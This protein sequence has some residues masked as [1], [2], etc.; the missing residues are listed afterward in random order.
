MSPYG[1]DKDLGGDSKPNDA[2][3]ERCVTRVMKSGKDKSSAIAICKSTM[4]KSKDNHSE[5]ELLLD[6]IL[7]NPNRVGLVLDTD[8]TKYPGQE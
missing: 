3:M 2:W 6:F 1:V 8:N 5:A 7:E 4:K